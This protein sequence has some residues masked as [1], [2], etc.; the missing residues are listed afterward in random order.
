[1]SR[2]R[3]REASEF[4]GVVEGELGGGGVGLALREGE[5]AY[6]EEGFDEDAAAGLRGAVV[7]LEAAVIAADA[8]FAGERV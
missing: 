7:R 2:K 5:E 8:E 1:M 4:A 3:E 6:L